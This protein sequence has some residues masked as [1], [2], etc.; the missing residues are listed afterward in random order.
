MVK[1][2]ANLIISV[3]IDI[4]A[5]AWPMRPIQIIVSNPTDLSRIIGFDGSLHS[6]KRGATGTASAYQS[7]GRIHGFGRSQIGRTKPTEIQYNLVQYNTRIHHPE[8]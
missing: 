2:G 7:A 3:R 4:F 8:A 5:A 1:L 6:D